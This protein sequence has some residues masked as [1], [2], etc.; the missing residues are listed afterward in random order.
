MVQNKQKSVTKNKV[1]CKKIL[2]D[3]WVNILSYQKVLL[4]VK[5]KK[6]TFFGY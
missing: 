5:Y 1:L 3:D 6:Y 2:Q 4:A